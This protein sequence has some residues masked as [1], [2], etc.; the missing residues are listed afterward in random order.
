MSISSISSACS[1]TVSGSVS[2]TDDA[3]DLGDD[4]VQAFDVLDV[5]RRPDVDAGGEQLLDILPALRMPRA[6]GVGVGQLVDQ[7]QL[8]LPRQ[9][10]VE[11]EFAQR[12]A[13]I[14]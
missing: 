10:G 9:R 11:I 14:R 2:R 6:F 1:S 4:V 13:A 3:G 7:D 5:E 8:R 12:H